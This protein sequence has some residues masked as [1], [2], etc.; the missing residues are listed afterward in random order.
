[1]IIELCRARYSELIEFDEFCPPNW[2]R[3]LMVVVIVARYWLVWAPLIA[4]MKSPLCPL[5]QTDSKFPT[6]EVVPILERLPW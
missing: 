1:M 5:R 2:V 3:L 4:E 6:D